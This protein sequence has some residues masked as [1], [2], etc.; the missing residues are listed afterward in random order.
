SIKSTFACRRGW[1]S[2]REPSRSRTR[3]KT[4]RSDAPAL[5]SSTLQRVKT[6]SATEGSTSARR[7]SSAFRLMNGAAG[8]SRCPACFAHLPSERPILSVSRSTSLLIGGLQEIACETAPV[9]PR[10]FEYLLAPRTS[11]LIFQPRPRAE[12]QFERCLL[13]GIDL[14]PFLFEQV[15]EM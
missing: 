9:R 11:G 10:V 15:E 3:S 5:I 13:R 4:L 2:S 1:S 7:H 14:G 6:V 12:Q 8:E